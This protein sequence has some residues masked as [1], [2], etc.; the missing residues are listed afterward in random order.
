VSR[1]PDLL[2][3]SLFGAEGL[4]SSRVELALREFTRGHLRLASAVEVAGMAEADFLDI[5][6]RRDLAEFRAPDP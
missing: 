4:P 5:L 3:A 2:A 1:A 6:A